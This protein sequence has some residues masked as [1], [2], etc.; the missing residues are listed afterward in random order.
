ME[1]HEVFDILCS[2]SGSC[3]QKISLV[4][5]TV[6]LHYTKT[7]GDAERTSQECATGLRVYEGAQ[8]LSSLLMQYIDALLGPRRDDVIPWAIELGCGCGLAGFSALRAM[9]EKGKKLHLLFTDASRECL[10]MVCR[11][12]DFQGLQIQPCDS[13]SP[14]E[15]SV[16][17]VFPLR[18]SS[19]GFDACAQFMSRTTYSPPSVKLLFG[20]DIL[21][22]RVDVEELVCT[23]RRLFELSAEPIFCILCHFM[24][25]PNGRFKL[26]EASRK[27][28]VGI[29]ELRTSCFIDPSVMSSRGW[30]GVEVVLLFPR[31]I[32]EQNG[33]DHQDVL[34]VKNILM[35][36]A[37]AF[38]ESSKAVE[39]EC[40]TLA[41][42]I[43]EYTLMEEKD[44]CFLDVDV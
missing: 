2:S 37:N 10:E 20:S 19:T 40:T 5:A 26:K 29:V 18:W 11:S 41:D 31:D 42:H 1:H 21:Y 16:G 34:A 35:R 17:S 4:C 39:E 12:G 13:A 43:V 8:M 9:K 24:R 36:R 28:G 3:S 33:N 44:T 38:S 25:I 7:T 23:I 15:G 27:A 6:G 32:Q 30:G 22:Y 14:R